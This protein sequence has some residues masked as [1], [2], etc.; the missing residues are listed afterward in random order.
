MSN[1]VIL[2]SIKS[3]H[4]VHLIIAG[5]E[6]KGMSY[7][8]ILTIKYQ[9][10]TKGPSHSLRS[11]RILGCHIKSYYILSIKSVPRFYLIIEVQKEPCM[12]NEVI[13]TIRY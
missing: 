12:S 4:G 5:K 11:R 10:G 9:K 7:E 13:L 1:E 2:T 3:Y 6:G 8:G